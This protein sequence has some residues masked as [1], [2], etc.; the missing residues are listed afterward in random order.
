M[1]GLSRSAQCANNLRQIYLAM[2]MYADDNQE[3]YP[4]AINVGVW[5]AADESQIGWMQRIYPYVKTPKIFRCPGQPKDT[6]N[7]FSYFLGCRAAYLAAGNQFSAF[8][9]KD[10][11]L[12]SQ[13]ILAG[14]TTYTSFSGADTDKDNY[15]QDCLFTWS[16]NLKRVPLYH[17]QRVN[18]LFGDGH[19]R[20]YTG[21]MATEMTYAYGQSGVDFDLTAP[22]H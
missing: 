14:D 9:R 7:D 1:R 19:V 3:Y 10:L 4:R 2:E 18:V 5:N 12:P 22:G 15:T 8:N 17:S 13:Y 11:L 6:E 20:S 16:Q 21:F